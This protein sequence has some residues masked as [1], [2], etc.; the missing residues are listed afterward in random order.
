MTGKKKKT[1]TCFW[2]SDLNTSMCLLPLV[3]R[4]PLENCTKLRD[5]ESFPR[6]Q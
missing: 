5:N 3:S 1:N 6:D 4:W 2:L